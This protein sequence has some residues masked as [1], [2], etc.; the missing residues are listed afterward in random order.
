MNLHRPRPRTARARGLRPA[1]RR[2]QATRT[3]R[4]AVVVLGLAMS[5]FAMAACQPLP[6]PAPGGTA[7]DCSDVAW[8][9]EPKDAVRLVGSP[10]VGVR[11]ASHRCFDRL[12]IDLRGG[13]AAGWHVRYGPVLQPG[14]GSPLGMDAATTLEVIAQAPAYDESGSSTFDPPD[15]GA[16]VDV[17]GFPTLRQVAFA[18]SFEGETTFG[19]GVRARLPYRVFAVEGSAGSKLVVD[20]AHRWA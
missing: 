8:G 4:V 2:P 13:P 20:V 5:V 16:L 11:A 19:L 10:I 3:P 6:G 18:G 15:A 14:L 9:S 1:P 7:P 17:R 12:V